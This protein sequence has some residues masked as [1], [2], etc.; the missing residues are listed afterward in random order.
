VS[1]ILSGG[2][3]LVIFIVMLGLLVF[4][5]EFGHF[6]VSKR[7]GIP[8][9]EFG[10]GFPPRALRFWRGNGWIEIQG[11]RILIPR[12]F[13]LPEKL[14]VG[15]YV[16]YKTKT[17]N[18]R[19][20]LT[21]LE[22]VDAEDAAPALASPVQALDRGTEYTLN[23]I[24]LG[25]FVRLMG[26]EDPSVPGGFASAKPMVRAPILLAGVTMNLIL[27]FVVF[28]MTAVASPPYV[29]V[30]TTSILEVVQGSPAAVAGLRKGD[31]IVAVNGQDVENN[32]P[33]LSDLLRANA[34]QPVT[35]TVVRNGK[36]LDPIQA[37]PRRNPPPGQ[38]A[39]GISLDGWLGLRVS[40]VT[41]GSV[42][43]RA[44]VRAGD[45]LVFVVDPKGRTLRDQNELVQFTQDHPGWKI[46]WRIQRD[47]QLLAPIT[48]QI[49]QTI[50]PQNAT[51]GLN[52]QTPI[53]DAPAVALGEMGSMIASIPMLFRQLLNGTAPANSFVGPIGIAQVTGEVAQRAGFLGLLSLL[54]L[55]S[56]NLAVVNLIPF[57]ALD[58]GRL[59]FVL[60]EWV[61]GGKKIDPQKEGM[62]HLVGIMVLLGL[63]VV[64]SFFDVQRLISGRSIFP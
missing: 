10:F 49:P 50:D 34:G 39:L 24:P 30:Q 56:V 51:L 40:S 18:Q 8:V 26:E 9:L 13:K 27:A 31:L 6:I 53:I 32:Y 64:I 23:W 63:M 47:N 42:A 46:E 19:E 44:G 17:E 16:I 37:E 14:S 15:S 4:V 35:L 12:S 61:R 20:V 2:A 33:A 29:P 38:G 36:T 59:I 41:P 11:R 48:V 28:T 45:V 25:G 58:G 1:T 21:S 43:D 60:L 22:L 62:V 54:G 7:L 3:N 57:P 5:H 55:L 52:L